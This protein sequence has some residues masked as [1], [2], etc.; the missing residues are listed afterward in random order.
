MSVATWSGMVYVAFIFDVFSRR[1]V[2]WWAAT[3]MT[4]DLTSGLTTLQ[5]STARSGSSRCPTTTRPKKR[6][7]MSENARPWAGRESRVYGLVRASNDRHEVALG[8]LRVG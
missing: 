3:R 4:T 1:I 6:H 8:V 2:G 5:A 7:G